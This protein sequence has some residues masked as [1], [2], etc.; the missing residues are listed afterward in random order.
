MRLILF[1]Y[2]MKIH[3]QISRAV[4][5]IAFHPHPEKVGSTLFLAKVIVTEES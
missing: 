5:R 3:L 1:H 4:V 2:K